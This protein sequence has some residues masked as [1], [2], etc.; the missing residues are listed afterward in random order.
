MKRARL[1]ASILAC[2]LAVACVTDVVAPTPGSPARDL[3]VDAEVLTASDAAADQDV[4]VDDAAEPGDVDDDET[5]DL[6]ADAQD[7][8][9]DGSG[10]EDEDATVDEDSA[11]DAPAD[12]PSTPGEVRVLTMNLQGLEG[13]WDARLEVLAPVVA[14]ANA[15]VM[16]FQE[17][18]NR[19]DDDNLDDLLARLRS[20]T[21]R[22]FD[23]ARA[24]ASE[25]AGTTEGLA[26]VTPHEIVEAADE[27]LPTGLVAR[28]ILMAR[29]ETPLGAIAIANL[30]LDPLGPATRRDQIATAL[31]S[32]RSFAGDRE[33]LV[34]VGDLNEPPGGDVYAICLGSGLLDVWG[35][36]RADDLGAT[37]P[38]DA[39][40][41]RIDYIWMWENR[42]GRLPVDTLLVGDTAVDG[43]LASDHLGVIGVLR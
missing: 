21:G 16:A 23:V 33:A 19:G 4:A 32:A 39:P 34:V 7:A 29:V 6:T 14:A 37:S 20:L 24:A 2:M 30:H 41:R 40:T 27:L 12:L 26:I 36:L 3:G 28:R 10:D 35:S 13:D 31:P 17:V 18:V 15:D 1:V 11:T 9:G 42:S 8:A 43:V 25:T 5:R 22:E 38:S